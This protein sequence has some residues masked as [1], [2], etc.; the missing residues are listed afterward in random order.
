MVGETPLEARYGIILDG[1]TPFPIIDESAGQ[2]LGMALLMASPRITNSSNVD[3]CDDCF[4]FLLRLALLCYD[5][6]HESAA[7]QAYCTNW[8]RDFF[9]R[10]CSEA[11]DG[12]GAAS[13]R[14]QT[15]AGSRCRRWE[16]KRKAEERN[17]TSATASLPQWELFRRRLQ[18]SEAAMKDLV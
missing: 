14:P 15:S 17:G 7:Q 16:C 13:T 2:A 10:W 9:G 5:T 11:T 1:M 8:S 12:H 18:S 4:I 6:R 3:V